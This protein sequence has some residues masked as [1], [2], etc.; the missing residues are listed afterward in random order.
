MS[1]KGRS[2][3]P[4]DSEELRVYFNV[5]EEVKGDGELTY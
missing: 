4:K 5:G 3:S 2:N 1:Y